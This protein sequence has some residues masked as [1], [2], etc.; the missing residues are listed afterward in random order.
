MTL[1]SSYGTSQLV[2]VVLGPTVRPGFG[3]PIREDV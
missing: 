3:T 2:V 1:N